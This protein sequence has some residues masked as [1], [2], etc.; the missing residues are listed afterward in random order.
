MTDIV[1]NFKF[2]GLMAGLL[3]IFVVP[4]VFMTKVAR[5][6]SDPCNYTDEVAACRRSFRN[7]L[8]Y[9]PGDENPMSWLEA[10]GMGFLTT[11][12][13][14]FLLAAAVAGFVWV[15]QNL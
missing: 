9:E 2:Y 1:D 8:F 13:L 6:E 11:V 12:F 3:S 14:F 15:A 7:R 4:W 10:T 5:E